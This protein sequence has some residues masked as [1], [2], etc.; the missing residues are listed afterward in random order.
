[1]RILK[2]SFNAGEFTPKLHSRYELSKY[3]NG[4]KTLTN[5]IPLPHGPI[6]RRPGF[7]YIAA[8]K[9]AAKYTRLIPFEFS[10]ED[11]YI[12]EFGHEYV[13]FYRN[14]GQIQSVDAATRLL[15]HCD[16]D[17]NSTTITDVGA[18]VHTVTANA[19]A[20]LKTAQKKFGSASCYFDGTGDYLSIPDHVDWDFGASEF[21]IDFGVRFDSVSQ[22]Q[23]IF[24]QRTDDSN[25]YSLW[26]NNLS[27]KL[28]FRQQ[29]TGAADI[30]LSYDW[31]PV[32]D[33]WYHIALIRGWS[34]N[35]NDWAI[36]VNGSSIGDET[37]A[38]S[39]LDL[40]GTFEVGRGNITA[41]PAY[42]YF[43]GYILQI[44]S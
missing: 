41:G 25:W 22:I 23:G 17:N 31:S 27:G 20:K 15:L 6:T 37:D 24:N 3:K 39:T 42:S 7:E 29:N 2:E 44:N 10:E 16:G 8:V 28:Q 18:T 5:F 30:L 38:D 43:Y 9:T 35:T 34:G 33:T 12:V 21:T 26:W 32:V 13:R 14:G 11:S 4:C 40:T 1:M 36:T 19:D